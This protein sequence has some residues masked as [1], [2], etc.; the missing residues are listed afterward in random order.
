MRVVHILKTG[1]IRGYI[2]IGV[3]AICFLTLVILAFIYGDLK[4]I[5]TDP[6]DPLVLEGVRNYMEESAFE[7]YHSATRTISAVGLLNAAIAVILRRRWRRRHPS[8]TLKK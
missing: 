5:S 2:C 4:S 8:T 6:S 7:K 1:F 3:A